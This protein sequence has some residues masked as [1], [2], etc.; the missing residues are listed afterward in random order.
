MAV[1]GTR[2]LGRP[3]K[4]TPDQRERITSNLVKDEDSLA[5]DSPHHVPTQQSVKHYVDNKYSQLRYTHTQS[6]SANPWPITHNLG[7]YPDVTI[8]K[9]VVGGGADDY[10]EVEA[11]IQHNSVNDLTI[12]LSGATSGKALMR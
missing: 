8:M 12:N 4:L 2:R 11:H 1:N 10:E 3:D 9:S 7:Y 6:T 5:S